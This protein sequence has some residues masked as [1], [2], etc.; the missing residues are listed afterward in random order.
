MNQDTPNPADAILE[1]SDIEIK[2][3][4]WVR[5]KHTK[6]LQNGY[7]VTVY[8]EDG[9]TVVREVK[10]PLYLIALDPDVR[11]FFPDGESVNATL[12]SLIALIPK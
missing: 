7:T 1:P 6:A 8:R 9:S 10:N 4:A 2:G 5:G 3:K 12:R 11:E